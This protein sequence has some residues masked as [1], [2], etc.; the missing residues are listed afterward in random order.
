[1]LCVYVWGVMDVVLSVSI[2]RHVAAG[3]RVWEVCEFRHADVSYVHPVAVLN[4][5]F[6][7]TCCSLMLIEDAR[8]T[9][10]KGSKRYKQLSCHSGY[11]L[12]CKLCQPSRPQQWGPDLQF[13]GKPAMLTRVMS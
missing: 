10:W 1:M 8:A 13:L 11:K 9:I 7:I 5:A 6:C 2:V 12:L 4:A 3:A